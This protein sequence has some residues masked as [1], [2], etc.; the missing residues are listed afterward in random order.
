MSSG[1]AYNIL[2][3]NRTDKNNQQDRILL[4]NEFLSNKMT[5][6]RKE[7]K[8]R[9]KNDIKEI[10]ICIDRCE[11]NLSIETDHS[12]KILLQSKIKELKDELM[13]RKLADPEPVIKD[14]T[15]DHHLFLQSSFK[16]FVS[17]GYEYSKASISP[18]PGFG[19]TIKV[20]IPK[21]GDFFNDM[22]V[23]VR[24]VGL[25]PINSAN[26]VQYCNFLGHRLFKKIRFVTNNIIL[27]EYTTEDY[28]FHYQFEVPDHKKNA[29]KK[30]VGQE[31]PVTAHLT[32]DPIFQN[33]REQISI[34]N[35]PQT[36]KN[37]HPEV[38][39]FVPLLFWFQDPKL[40]IPNITLPFGQTFLEF[41][42]ATKDEV[43]ACA[44]FAQDDGL[45][46]TPQMLDFHLYTNHIYLNPDILDLFIK[47]IGLTLIRIHKRQEIIL[48]QSFNEML[49]NEIKYPIELMYVAFR[50]TENTTGTDHMNT[51]NLNSKL[52]RTLIPTPV[53][54]DTTGNGDYGLGT[55]SIIY[56]AEDKVVNELGLKADNITIYN[57]KASLFY[58][59]YLPYHYGLQ[60][61]SPPDKSTYMF[62][63]NF[64]PQSYQP[65]GYLNLSK[66]RRFYIYYNSDVVG[67]TST[68]KMIVSARAINF[69]LLKQG[70]LTLQYNV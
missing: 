54:Y 61:T 43:C 2:V 29:W 10:I 19:S 53:M 52:T 59:S 46:E 1:G 36:L 33:F 45:F 39:L 40:A 11:D 22:V 37:E 5:K 21:Y 51:W 7:K 63:F 38:E 31:V 69:L 35:G 3:G 56:N 17:I 28:N 13:K 4:A 30:C 41:D 24:L 49:L 16:P 8:H 48:N 64:D 20:K 67:P 65:T 50:P 44:N 58:N 9:I 27:D 57:Q 42:L 23:Y 15:N 47:R 55:N 66:I 62:T 68:C 70:T 34:L 25:K 6:L 32:S 18:I 60:T 14:I 26:K 12:R